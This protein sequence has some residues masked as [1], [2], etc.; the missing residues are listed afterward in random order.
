MVLG[1]RIQGS[2]RHR[3]PDPDPQHCCDHWYT[4]PERHHFQP[5]TLRNLDFN[6]DPDS[7]FDFHVDPNPDPFFHS[8]PN[9]DPASQ[10][11]A[12]PYGSGSVTLH[13]SLPRN[14]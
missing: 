13:A 1:S 4:D 10:N 6:A 3:I 7:A 9:L 12:K 8:D 5:P 14:I 2:K 11:D